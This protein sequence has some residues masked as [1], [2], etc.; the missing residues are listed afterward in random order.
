MLR[1]K[2][3]PGSLLIARLDV[4]MRS[5]YC[6]NHNSRATKANNRSS[7]EKEQITLFFSA[8]YLFLLHDL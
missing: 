4:G 6:G 5:G 2:V 7:G 1:G 8:V 3:L